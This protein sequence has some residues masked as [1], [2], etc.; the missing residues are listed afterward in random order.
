MG[1]GAPGHR[2]RVAVWT[3]QGWPIFIGDNSDPVRWNDETSRIPVIALCR[4]SSR[5]P[6]GG[7]K[8]MRDAPSNL[9]RTFPAVGRRGLLPSVLMPR[10]VLSEKVLFKRRR[11]YPCHVPSISGRKEPRTVPLA[12]SFNPI[13][14]QKKSFM[15]SVY[16]SGWAISCGTRKHR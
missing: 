11:P 12:P 7:G 6:T 4:S 1:Q 15:L 3:R 10:E 2:G 16:C 8:F 5:N 13:E 9:P 14:K